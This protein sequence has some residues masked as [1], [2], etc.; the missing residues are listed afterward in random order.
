MAKDKGQSVEPRQ[1]SKEILRWT[2]DM[3]Q[4][5]LNALMEEANKGN[6]H[7]GAWT[8]EAY[9]NVVD[10]LRSLV[11]PT[12]TKQHIKNRMK[13]LKDHFAESY[14]LFG[15]LSGFEWNPTTRRFEAENEEKPHAAKWK[16]MQ[17]KH[18]GVLKELFG[19]DRAVGKNPLL[20]E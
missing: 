11:A 15:S 1:V 13:T 18:Y 12:M 16:T 20:I 9:S 14:D 2:D 19:L 6:R 3:D 7:D 4:I 5:L 17:I 10:A 8:I